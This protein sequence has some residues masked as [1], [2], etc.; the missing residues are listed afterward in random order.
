[1]HILI[2]DDEECVRDSLAIYLED[3]GHKV[4]VADNPF[5]CRI[6]LHGCCD[7]PFPCADVLL[8]DQNMPG[9]KG[10]EFIRLQN[11]R[12]CKAAASAKMIMSGKVTADLVN[13]ANELGC[14]L[15]QKPFSFKVLDGFLREVAERRRGAFDQNV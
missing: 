7:Q 2:I 9:M 11:E 14:R 4:T 3:Q 1:M 6:T 5:S 13:E 15:V 8:I 12:G 10:T